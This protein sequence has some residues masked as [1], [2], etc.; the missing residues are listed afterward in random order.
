MWTRAF[1]VDAG[2]RAL[3]TFVQAFLAVVSVGAVLAAVQSGD[4]V[5][6][7][8]LAYVGLASGG[9]AALF[10]VLKAVAAAFTGERGTA[11]FGVSTYLGE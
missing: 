10:S 3:A 7:W 6:A 11:Q 4:F 2:E 8:N 1:W 5:G 9:V